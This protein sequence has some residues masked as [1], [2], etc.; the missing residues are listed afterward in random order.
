LIYHRKKFSAM[1]KS[2]ES[3]SFNFCSNPSEKKSLKSMD[4]NSPASNA[5][6]HSEQKGTS[7]SLICSEGQ[8][9]HFTGFTCPVRHTLQNRPIVNYFGPYGLSIDIF[10]INTIK[11]QSVISQIIKVERAH[12]DQF[13]LGLF[14]RGKVLDGDGPLLDLVVSEDHEIVRTR[15]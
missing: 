6:Q 10:F 13:Y 2:S 8:K 7:S 12:V 9:E 11:Y 3:T 15:L 5:A 4:G 14:F 1:L